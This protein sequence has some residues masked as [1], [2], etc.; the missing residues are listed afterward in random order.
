MVNKEISISD[1]LFSEVTLYAFRYALGRRT[2]AVN[3]M[4]AI[5]TE[6]WKEYPIEIRQIIVKEIQQAKERDQLGDS[7]DITDWEK[8]LELHNE[9]ESK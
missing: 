1:I 4:V 8:I 2:Y 5:L 6:Y 7:C 3:S 9:T